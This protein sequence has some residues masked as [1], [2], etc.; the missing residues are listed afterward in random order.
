VDSVS[1]NDSMKFLETLNW[2]LREAGR[3][4]RTIELEFRMPSESEW[5]AAC[6]ADG[7]TRFSGGDDLASLEREGWFC[8]NAAGS[9]HPVG[10]KAP[11]AWGLYDMLGNVREPC[12]DAWHKTYRNAPA[13]GSPWL[14]R[15]RSP[16]RVLRGGSFQ[17][18]GEACRSASRACASPGQP[19]PRQGLRLCLGPIGKTIR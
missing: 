6:R 19:D 4:A 10:R 13:G 11:N 15:S 18:A 16:P 5:E 3:C 12:L 7:E 1:W 2:K 14:G 8:G 9:T 17:E